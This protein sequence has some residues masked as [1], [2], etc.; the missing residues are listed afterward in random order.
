MP[1]GHPLVIAGDEAVDDIG[2]K[3]PFAPVE[4]PHDAE[5][6]RH[7]V[8]G[9]GV[10]K[11]IARMHVGVEI[12]VADGVPKKTL[13]DLAG[14]LPAIETRRIEGCEIPDGN[15]IDPVRGEHGV[16]G[17]VPADRR[18]A[19]PRVLFD[20]AGELGDRSR[21]EPQIELELC[22]IIEG[23]DHI[24]G[25]E[26]AQVAHEGFGEARA[27]IVALDVVA[28]A[29]PHAGPQDFYRNLAAKAVPQH[30]SLVHLRNRGGGDGRRQFRELGGARSQRIS[31]QLGHQRLVERLHLVLQHR[32]LRREGGTDNIGSG[33]E[34]LAE[35]DVGRPELVE[36]PRQ[37][38]DAAGALDVAALE[39]PAEPD[40]G[41]EHRRQGL[42]VGHRQRALAGQ[43]PAG[44]H[45]SEVGGEAHGA[46]RGN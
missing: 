13:Q 21:L 39:Q 3:P 31:Q 7:D 24:E 6:D 36:R 42:A 19:E 32:Q 27:G 12:A 4:P 17:M 28:K 22:G 20:I 44:A 18:R 1:L 26:A 29:L 25:P 10:G 11:Q 38:L 30:D 5:I 34:G 33:G 37:P 9:F 43:H 14:Q 16:C 46:I 45:E 40:A 23:L 41:A 15:T 2:K 35:F 8:A